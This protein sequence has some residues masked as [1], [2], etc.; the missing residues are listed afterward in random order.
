MTAARRKTF[1]ECS[2]HLRGQHTTAPTAA[3]SA[4]RSRLGYGLKMVR[5]AGFGR[6]HPVV[7]D[8]AAF[9][10]AIERDTHGDHAENQCQSPEHDG[11]APCLIIRPQVGHF[12]AARSA[13]PFPPDTR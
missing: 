12:Q 2:L 5:L 11:P 6:L 9:G 1:M 10:A 7:P 3:P 13:C 8:R 4:P